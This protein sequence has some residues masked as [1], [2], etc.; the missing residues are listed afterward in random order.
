V[1]LRSALP[2]LLIAG[3]AVASTLAVVLTRDRPTTEETEARARNLLRVF[4]EEEL[5]R[6]ALYDTN[7]LVLE[8]RGE[9]DTRT[10]VLL[11]EGEP[12]DRDAVD[13]LIAGLGFAVPARASSETPGAAGIGEKSKKIELSSESVRYE[14]RLGKPTEPPS[15]G[16]YLELRAEGAPGSGVYVVPKDVVALFSTDRD[17]LRD[18]RLFPFGEHSLAALEVETRTA[19]T[20]VEHASGLAWKLES[21]KRASRTALEPWF[22]AL[23][24]LKLEEFLDRRA[25]LSLIGNTPEARVRATPRE[26]AALSLDFGG[27]CP[28][29]PDK[30][31]VVDPSTNGKAGCV[32]RTV[33][34]RLALDPGALIDR[35]PFSARPDEV[36]ELTIERGGQALVLVRKGTAFR[37]RRPSEAEVRSDA[38]NARLSAVVRAP[39]EIV[40]DPDVKALGLDPPEG[41]VKVVSPGDGTS[42]EEILELGKRT[43]DGTLYVRRSDGVVLSLARDA[44]R[45]FEIDTTLLRSPTLLSFSQS[46]LESVT[47][48]T[49]EPQTI[50]RGPSGALELE[51]PSGFTL[52]SGLATE[53]GFT[54]GALTATSFVSDRDDGSF[55]LAKPRSRATLSF[56]SGDAGTRTRTLLVG[57]PTRAGYY[58]RFE[59]DPAVFVL[60]RETVEKLEQLFVDRGAFVVDPERITRVELESKG[61]RV[62][63]AERGGRLAAVSPNDFSPS[64]VQG[65]LDAL[66]ALRA[67]SALHTGPAR[68]EEGFGKPTLSVRVERKGSEKPLVFTLGA[69][70]EHRGVSVLYARA[71]GVDATFVIAKSKLRPLLDLF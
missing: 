23:A 10:W 64:L 35:F 66:G 34:E 69:A 55:G 43:A 27:A 67:D 45:A 58:A 49:P 60:D 47:L 18:A 53:L 46:E 36:E 32:S 41:R 15:G 19:K 3:L 57:A 61:E 8:R 59:D 56:E 6:I 52:D 50:R 31:V 71:K 51:S 33:L 62:V 4:R 12:A 48:S 54:L 22:D 13:R 26:G 42:S 65:V 44:A 21:G 5:S 25:A 14:L 2:H 29:D 30:I 38:G 7:T 9:G 40:A 39:A 70:D 24:G 1:K 28:G 20:R 17:A 11:P 37:L 63:L 16:A 68:P